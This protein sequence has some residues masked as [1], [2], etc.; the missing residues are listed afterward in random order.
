MQ[1]EAEREE[2]LREKERKHEERMMLM[3]S[4]ALHQLTSARGFPPQVHD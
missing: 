1:E 2:R 4:G 3:L